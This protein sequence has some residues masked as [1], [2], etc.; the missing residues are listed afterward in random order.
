MVAG[1]NRHRRGMCV[2]WLIM[3]R[4]KLELEDM[5]RIS[6]VVLYVSRPKWFYWKSINR[7]EFDLLDCARRKD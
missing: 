5:R 7:A 1:D 6:T 2:L 3:S 4:I